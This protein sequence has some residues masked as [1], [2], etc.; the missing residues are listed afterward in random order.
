[1]KKEEIE[2]IIK[3][4]EAREVAHGFESYDCNPVWMVVERGDSIY[5]IAEYD[6]PEVACNEPEVNVYEPRRDSEEWLV[7]EIGRAHV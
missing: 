7:S 3:C 4:Y 5:V 1:M 6:T 2:G